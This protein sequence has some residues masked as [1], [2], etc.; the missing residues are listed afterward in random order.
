MI[1]Y[2]SKKKLAL[3][4]E[5]IRTLQGNELRAVI[6]GQTLAGCSAQCSADVCPDTQFIHGCN[7]QTVTCPGTNE[8]GSIV[9]CT[10]AGC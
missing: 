6:G 10:S 8:C 9:D 1:M 2:K 5:T 3:S 4:A 7:G